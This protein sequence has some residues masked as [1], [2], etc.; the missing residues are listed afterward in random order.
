MKLHEQIKHYRLKAKLSQF[1][2]AK[3]SG[4]ARSFITLLENGNRDLTV[5]TMLKLFKA[6]DI[7]VNFVMYK[8]NK[9]LVLRSK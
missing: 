1:E 2:L 5:K 7:D 8:H 9:K 4:F 6:M 3:K